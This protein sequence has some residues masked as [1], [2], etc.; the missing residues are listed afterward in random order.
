MRGGWQSTPILDGSR[1]SR[2]GFCSSETEQKWVCSHLIHPKQ[3]KIG[4]GC[5]PPLITS[6]DLFI[7]FNGGGMSR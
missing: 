3:Y 2:P 5:R 6:P 1:D 7:P 4:A